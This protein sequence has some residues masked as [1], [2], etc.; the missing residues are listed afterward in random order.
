MVSSGDRQD[1]E[2]ECSSYLNRIY[3]FM[4]ISVLACDAAEGSAKIIIEILIHEVMGYISK[5]C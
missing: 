4:Q 3:H 5:T 2:L 1:L